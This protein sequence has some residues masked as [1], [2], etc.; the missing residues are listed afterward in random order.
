L[1][2]RKLGRHIATGQ[3]MSFVQI[4]PA[5]STFWARAI[6]VLLLFGATAFAVSGLLLAIS[7]YKAAK[8]RDWSAA[9]IGVALTAICAICAAGLVF[10]S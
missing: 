4:A 1:K 3:S 5:A 7:A 2:L 6:S 10:L 9:T 8:D